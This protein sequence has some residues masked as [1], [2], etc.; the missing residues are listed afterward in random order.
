[1][2]KQ[3]KAGVG[4]GVIVDR[5]EQIPTIL[6]DAHHRRSDLRMI[7]MA[8]RRGWK[9]PETIMEQL[10]EVL[11][12]LATKSEDDRTRI[13][14]ARVLVAMHGQNQNEEP[15]TKYVEHHHAHELGPVT[16]ETIDERRARLHQQLDRLR[17]RD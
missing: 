14:A 2:A 9:I 7:G 16:G 4:C 15:V 12:N 6:T 11:A 1:M 5:V 10:P 3:K 17:N 8:I 13:G